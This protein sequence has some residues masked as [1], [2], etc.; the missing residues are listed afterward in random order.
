MNEAWQALTSI[1]EDEGVDPSSLSPQEI[2]TQLGTAWEEQEPLLRT[3]L[4][5]SE[6]DMADLAQSVE[7]GI[8]GVLER[9]RRLP[10]VLF[11][12]QWE[13]TFENLSQELREL[14]VAYEGLET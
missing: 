4:G 2:R 8:E 7:A 9:L 6:T 14:A 3:Q 10:D 13:R 12:D 1:L 5:L 11:D